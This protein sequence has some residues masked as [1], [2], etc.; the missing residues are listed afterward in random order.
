[1]SSSNPDPALTRAKAV[2]L[3]L[4]DLQSSEERSAMIQQ[5]QEDGVD[6]ADKFQLEFDNWIEDAKAAAAEAKDL[7][8]AA[9]TLSSKVPD[10]VDFFQRLATACTYIILGEGVNEDPDEM[11]S[12]W[13]YEDEIRAKGGSVDP[14]QAKVLQMMHFFGLD[15]FIREL[16]CLATLDPFLQL[17][18]SDDAR[19]EPFYTVAIAKSYDLISSLDITLGGSMTPFMQFCGACG[20]ASKVLPDML[21]VSEGFQ[22]G[23]GTLAEEIRDEG[24]ILHAFVESDSGRRT[25]NRSWEVCVA[26]SIVLNL[27][28][29]LQAQNADNQTPMSLAS[30]TDG[31]VFGFFVRASLSGL[32]RTPY[33]AHGTG[34]SVSG[35]VGGVGESKEAATK[36]EV[37]ALRDELRETKQQLGN[38]LLLFGKLLGLQQQQDPKTSGKS[39]LEEQQNADDEISSEN[40]SD[41]DVDENDDAKRGGDI[42]IV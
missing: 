1:M 33:G 40:S 10:L 38:I 4:D 24:T 41:S 11:N 9:E 39:K 8:G 21:E 13:W 30:T 28:A 25:P 37:Q 7:R 15:G 27:G 5:L 29:S 22:N 18:D 2:D 31:I 32:S 12:F 19:F 26:S 23:Y 42:A 3:I 35:V 16:V 17:L 6:G 20:F 34:S 14:V 36:A